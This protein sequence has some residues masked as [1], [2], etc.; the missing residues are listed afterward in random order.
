MKSGS[1]LIGQACC[2]GDRR[3]YNTALI[4][5]DA[6]FAPQWAAQQ[7]ST[8]RALEQLATEPTV[9]AAVQEASTPPTSTWP[10]SSRSRSSRSCPG[11]G[12][13]AATS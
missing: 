3:P 2:I 13:P 7:G 5:L 8:R 6:D 1:P 10:G 9:I 11:T 4:V 12:C